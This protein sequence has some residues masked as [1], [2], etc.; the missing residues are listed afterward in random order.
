MNLLNTPI[1][2]QIAEELYYAVR[3]IDLEFQ[4]KKQK[5]RREWEKKYGIPVDRNC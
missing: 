2:E 1:N 3:K 5:M 4:M